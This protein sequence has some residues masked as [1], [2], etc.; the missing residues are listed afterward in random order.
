MSDLTHAEAVEAFKAFAKEVSP[1]A[2]VIVGLN[3]NQYCRN[4]APLHA[5]LYPRGVGY[6]RAFSVDGDTYADLLANTRAAWADH[7]DK[8]GAETIR[9]MALQI[10]SIT[11]DEGSCSEFS[12]CK[13]FSA[14][15]VKTYGD[16]ACE[17]A[18]RIAGNGPFSIVRADEAAQIVDRS[19]A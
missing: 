12:L 7:G 17:E 16:R 4:V 1:Q 2:S 9:N 15:E 14:G 8:H 5:T 6:D 19:A 18:T 13:A 11:A 3:A 10:I